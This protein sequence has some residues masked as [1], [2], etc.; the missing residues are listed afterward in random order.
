MELEVIFTEQDTLQTFFSR[1]SCI[2][3]VDC[4]CIV[5]IDRI[6]LA[7]LSSEE[8]F[9]LAEFL[10]DR[11]M[12]NRPTFTSISLDIQTHQYSPTYN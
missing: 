9:I 5:K 3:T 12:V 2:H 10:Q 4:P 1:Y 7:M 8:I 11:N 6:A